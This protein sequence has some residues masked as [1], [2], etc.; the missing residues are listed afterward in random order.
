LLAVFEIDDKPI[1]L[2]IEDNSIAET[3]YLIIEIK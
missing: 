2:Q 3:A 1:L